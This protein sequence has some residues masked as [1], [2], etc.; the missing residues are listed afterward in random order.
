MNEIK[1]KLVALEAK[2]D[3]KLFALPL[4]GA[5]GASR[6]AKMVTGPMMTPASYRN[7]AGARYSLRGRGRRLV[8]AGGIVGGGLGAARLGAAGAGVGGVAGA[9]DSI[10]DPNKGII[11]G[12]LGG[13]VSGGL[14]GGALGGGIGA[15]RGMNVGRRMA[16]SKRFH[17]TMRQRRPVDAVAAAFEIKQRLVELATKPNYKGQVPDNNIRRGMMGFLTPGAS[18]TS[19]VGAIHNADR[20]RA[21]GQVYRKRDAMGHSVVGGAAGIPVSTAGVVGGMSLVNK[22]RT[23]AGTGVMGAGLLGAL[24]IG[25][26]VSRAMGD[27]SLRKRKAGQA[28][29]FEIKQRLVELAQGKYQTGTATILGNP[30]TAAMNAKKGKKLDAFGEAYGHGL[31]E[32]VKG[33]GVGAGAGAAV[34]ASAATGS[35]IGG[36]VAKQQMR[37]KVRSV[38]SGRVPRLGSKA[39]LGRIGGL[40]LPAALIGGAG[41][42][43]IGALKGN[44]DKKAREIRNKYVQ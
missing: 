42:A 24:G 18:I 28:P 43:W 25:Y 22:G 7:L 20:F 5:L 44:F 40:A 29:M 19:A 1:N 21:A 30:I 11:G 34:G 9:V 12:A 38:S 2:V 17:Q 26:G 33:L 32:A 14:M 39:V 8:S 4:L 10:G 37:G 23:L 31:I 35:M 36:T 27:R 13:A 15:A 16:Q 6:V 3:A 41:G